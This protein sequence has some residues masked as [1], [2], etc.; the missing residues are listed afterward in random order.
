[1]VVVSPIKRRPSKA[2]GLP[3][4]LFFVVAQFDS[5]NGTMTSLPHIP[6]RPPLFSNSSPIVATNY[7]LIVVYYNQTV[8]I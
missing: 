7:W 3:I 5:P 8:A 6:P 4:S 2:K 1:L